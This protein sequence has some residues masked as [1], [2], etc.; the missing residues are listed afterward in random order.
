M[1]YKWTIRR[2][3]NE[4]QHDAGRYAAKQKGITDN[5]YPEL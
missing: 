1:K 4:I 3:A 5:I 2:K